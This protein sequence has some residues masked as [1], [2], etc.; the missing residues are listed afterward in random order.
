MK[1]VVSFAVF[2]LTCLC[3]LLATERQALAYV[4]PGSGLLALQSFASV[5]AAAG[6][7]LRRRIVNL[8]SRK[9]PSADAAPAAENDSAA[10]K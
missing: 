5:I 3:F 1:R 9:K 8:F 4:D 6:F 7:V 10:G 2:S